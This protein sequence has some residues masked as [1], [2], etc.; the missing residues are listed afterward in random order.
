MAQAGTGRAVRV[1]EWTRITTFDTPGLWDCAK[2]RRHGTWS[3]NRDLAPSARGICWRSGVAIRSG[4]G[5]QRGSKPW[6]MCAI[7]ILILT[8]VV[9]LVGEIAA[10]ERDGHLAGVRPVGERIYCVCEVFARRIATVAG[11]GAEVVNTLS[12]VSAG[13]P[14]ELDGCSLL[15]AY[16]SRAERRLPPRSV[17]PR[18]TEFLGLRSVGRRERAHSRLIYF[19]FRFVRPESRPKWRQ[20]AAPLS[21]PNSSANLRAASVLISRGS[22]RGC[23][24]QA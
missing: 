1:L 13:A 7:D 23:L 19:A 14:M 4:F 12:R 9:S 11:V 22:C 6:L 3:R 18:G 20:S 10:P 2:T 8:F 21:P 16:R 17:L 5:L 15:R 24:S